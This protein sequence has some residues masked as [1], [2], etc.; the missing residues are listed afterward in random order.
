MAD[1]TTT[2]TAYYLMSTPMTPGRFGEV[3]GSHWAIEN[4]TDHAP[5]NLA[6]LRH[7]ALNLVR[8]ETSKGSLRKK[9]RRAAWSDSVIA[10][11]LAQ[12]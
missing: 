6:I 1:K 4:R 3:V 8:Q 7:M 5:Q 9:L 10:K 11:V 12:L 2:E